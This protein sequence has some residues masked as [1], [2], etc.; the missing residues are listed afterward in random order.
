VVVTD[1]APGP[2][3]QTITITAPKYGENTLHVSA[4]NAAL[5]EG[6]SS[7]TIDV[8]RLSPPVAAWRLDTY[9][10][11]DQSRALADIRPE[12]AGDTPLT[13]SNV[14]WRP[15]QRLVRGASAEFNG[16]T[17]VMTAAGA[18]VDT[19]RSFTVAAWVRL[20]EL[21]TTTD[22]MVAAQDGTDAAG[23]HLGT[24][25]EGSP[26]T[27]RWGFVMKDGPALQTV[28]RSK[29]RPRGL[30]CGFV[31]RCGC[32]RGQAE[33][34]IPSFGYLILRQLLQLMI[35]VLCG[36]RATEAEILVLR[37]R[38]AVLRRHVHR[39]DLEPSDRAVLAALSRLLPRPRWAAFF[40]TP[41]TLLRWHRRLV[42]RQRT[43]S[44]RPDRPATRSEIRDPGAAPGRAEPDLGLPADSG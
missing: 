39:L 13:A 17:S 44:G 33:A 41:A 6:H 24:R 12:P 3:T 10:G 15:D 35:L 27:P 43:Y 25:R 32:C 34:M 37:H 18:P 7:T 19:S 22:I 36:D 31:R 23:F 20:S 11:V 28:Y 16:T 2:R 29:A 8:G 9:P 40:V 14:T 4:I 21:P 26:L 30:T 38:V 5:S 42:T 1:T